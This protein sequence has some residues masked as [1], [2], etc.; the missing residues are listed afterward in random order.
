HLTAAQAQIDVVQHG[1]RVRRAVSVCTL[2]GTGWVAER[3]P[4][5]ADLLREAR[6]LTRAVG[7]PLGLVEHLEEPLGTGKTLRHSLARAA[8]VL[9]WLVQEHDG[10]EKGDDPLGLESA[11]L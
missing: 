8:E 10:G 5:E 9:E 7:K 1:G 11:Q 2:C 4:L 6:Q 3:D